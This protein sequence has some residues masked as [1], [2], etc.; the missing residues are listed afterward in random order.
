MLSLSVVT[1][2]PVRYF[3]FVSGAKAQI[4]PVLLG[5]RNGFSSQLNFYIFVHILLGA[6]PSNRMP[7]YVGAVANSTVQLRLS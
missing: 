6:L 7:N 1:H 2:R 3:A 5:S 4:S